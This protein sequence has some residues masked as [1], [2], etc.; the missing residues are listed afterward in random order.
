MV[1][2]LNVLFLSAEAAPLAKVGGL[3]DVGGE[4]PAAL[5]RGGL[6]VRCALPRYPTIA[7]DPSALARRK[8]VE[9]V[10]GGEA[11]EAWLVRRRVWGTEYLLIDG[12]P[13]ARAADIY[14][15]GAVEG[16][17][18]VFWA[19]ASLEACRALGWQ[20]DV[21]HAHDW[22]AAAA[23]AWL[24]AHRREDPFWRRTA[25]VFTV[26]NLGYAGAGA[27]GAWQGYGLPPAEG[28]PEWARWLP[29]A[30][31]LSRADWLTTVS[32]TY[33]SEIATPESG[34]GLDPIVAARRSRLTGILNG[35]DPA[36]W[37]PATDRALVARYSA[38][39]LDRR[40]R[41]KQSLQAELGLDEQ[42]APLL[43]FVGRLEHQKGVDL[44]L[45][46]LA[47]MT[48][49]PWEAVVLGTG[50]PDLEAMAASFEQGHSGRL[51]YRPVFDPHLA[52][53]IYG[54]A[55][56]VVVPS[57]YE[58]CGLVQM[59]AMRYGAVPVVRATGGL[60]DTVRDH[61]AGSGTGFVFADTSSEA[62]AA[63]LRRGLAA[64]NDRRAWRSLQR[65]AMRQDFSWERPARQ[66]AAV[67]RR[68]LRVV[69]SG[70]S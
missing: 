54:S 23:V 34:F 64:Y 43:A 62:L 42:E 47:T 19:L 69:G 53:R 4:L 17:K 50:H 41:N 35:I 70:R 1:R 33:A 52:R 49:L 29:L 44:L 28:G 66:Y 57:R 46:A 61:A 38:D 59:I 63:A 31:G 55:D 7:L 12:A 18:F 24:A 58:P 5:R 67:Y 13:V 30:S 48:D 25:T 26:H 6:T 8:R 2:P 16:E 68:A 21:V 39:S 45:Q 20:P 11:I 3:G 27:E 40:R 9:V 65:R 10:R 51:R 36:V 22:H 37:N 56:L 14:G 15:G 60:R 32:P